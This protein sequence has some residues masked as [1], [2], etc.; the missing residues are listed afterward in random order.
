MEEVFCRSI[1]KIHM[2]L[3]RFKSETSFETWV[4]FIFIHTC[5]ELS[6]N[7]NL[8]ASEEGEQHKDFFNALD[9]LQPTCDVG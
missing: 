1:I 4:T 6:D 3:H 8:Q 5:R 9:Q 2:N 7:R